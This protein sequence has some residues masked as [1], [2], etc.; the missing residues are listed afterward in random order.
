MYLAAMLTNSNASF[1]E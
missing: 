1:F